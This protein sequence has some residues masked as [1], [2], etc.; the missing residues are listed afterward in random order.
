MEKKIEIPVELLKQFIAELEKNIEI[1]VY[2]ENKRWLEGR[3]HAYQTLLEI[4]EN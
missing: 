2:P 1:A 3:V 4:F